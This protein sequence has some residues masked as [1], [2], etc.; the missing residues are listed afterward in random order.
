[1]NQLR[2]QH[3]FLELNGFLL[4]LGCIDGTHVPS[5]AP[6]RNEDLYVNRKN[7]QSINV[8]A[9]CD[10]D[11]KLFTLSPNCLVALRCI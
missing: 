2:N 3:T 7:F 8:Q 1:M 6:L 9:M 5:F 4:V 10:R 11:F